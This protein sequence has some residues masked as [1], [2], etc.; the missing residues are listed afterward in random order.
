MI[1]IRVITGT[2]EK[3]CRPM[4][5]L[6]RSVAVASEVMLML[7]VLLAKMAPASAAALSSPQVWRL[8]ASS[9]KTAS[10]RMSW[11]P[12]RSAPTPVEMRA[13]IPSA[14]SCASRPFSTERARL[15][16]IRPFPFSASS[17][18]RSASVTTLPAAALTW[19]MPCPI[20]PAP[21]TKTRSRLMAE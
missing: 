9:S 15:P 19:A 20:S 17:A 21:M 11:P 16:A 4:K 12:A 2:G 3:K 13:R 18:V 8:T 5:R 6:G 7:L 1:S 14:S 10:I